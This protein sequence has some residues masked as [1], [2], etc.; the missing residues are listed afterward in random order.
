MA[1]RLVQSLGLSDFALVFDT[2]YPREEKRGEAI[3][4]LLVWR[5]E[6]GPQKQQKIKSYL[7]T[8]AEVETPVELVNVALL[9]SLLPGPVVLKV[10]EK[11]GYGLFAERDYAPAERLTD[12]GGRL[13]DKPESG[14]YVVDLQYS[15]SSGNWKVC[16]LDALYGFSPADKGRWVNEGPAVNVQLKKY[17]KEKRAYFVVS[18]VHVKRGQQFYWDYGQEYD[19]SNY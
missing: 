9:A 6:I 12:Y 2:I 18:G 8:Q 4:Q 7:V 11:V 1:S 5:E 15:D 17:P 16:S 10:N 3:A 19:R 14:P 13:L